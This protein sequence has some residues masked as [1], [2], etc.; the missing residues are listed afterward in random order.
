MVPLELPTD[1]SSYTFLGKIGQ[2][3]FASVWKAQTT[4]SSSSSLS[5]S[6]S[7]SSK[8]AGPLQEQQHPPP[9]E[10]KEC[11]SP[12]VVVAIKVLNLDHVDSDLQEIRMILNLQ[13][14]LPLK[15]SAL[16]KKKI[17]HLI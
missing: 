4:V 8:A 16:M 10:N 9:P 12:T 11:N 15:R 5:S 1:A 6:L 3:A 14:H 13:L 17:Q 2:G 7:S